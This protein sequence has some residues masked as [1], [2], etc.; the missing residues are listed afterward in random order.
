[1]KYAIA[2]LLASTSAIQIRQQSTATFNGSKAQ[3]DANFMRMWNQSTQTLTGAL[4]KN[5]TYGGKFY[6]PTFIADSSMLYNDLQTS[7]GQASGVANYKDQIEKKDGDSGVKY[8]RISDKVPGPLSL[9]GTEGIN[10][11]I[12]EQGYDGD[13]WFLSQASSLAEYPDRIKAV[14]PG[15]DTYSDNGAFQVRI[16]VRGEP[17][18][19]VVDDI[20]PV[21]G[22]SGTPGN[23][24]SPLNNS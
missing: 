24:F 4:V 22:Y 1:M 5:N 17:V 8:Q 12:S 16:F 10:V 13:C 7:T 15:Q 6:D 2:S 21:Y 14:F 19:V 18:F 3:C 9:W 11:K 23:P 20:I